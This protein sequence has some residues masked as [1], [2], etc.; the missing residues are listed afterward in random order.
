MRSPLSASAAALAALLALILLAPPAAAQAPE[1]QPV[2][3]DEVLQA[4][5]K[6]DAEVVVLNMWATWCVPCVEE[7][8]DLVRLDRDVE[9][10]DVMFVSADFDEALPEAR[11]FLAEQGISGTTFL[12]DQKDNVFVSA[13]GEQW[14]G[15]LPATFIYDRD[16][17]L[18][19]FWEGIATYEKLKSHVEPLLTP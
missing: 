13:F 7:F 18:A 17:N 5:N 8:P 12:K 2:T 19:H 9:G 14:S 3:A 16:R 11:E 10:V 15:A 6:N 4:V 1:L